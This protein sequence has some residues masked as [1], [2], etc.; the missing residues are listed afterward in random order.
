MQRVQKQLVDAA[1]W[2]PLANKFH[3]AIRDGFYMIIDSP[4]F[5]FRSHSIYATAMRYRR[6][7]RLNKGKVNPDDFKHISIDELR[8]AMVMLDV[9]KGPLGKIDFRVFN[10][11]YYVA[12]A[13]TCYNFW[14]FM[15]K[16][17]ERTENDGMTL[18]QRKRMF[19]S[20]YEEELRPK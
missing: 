11:C 15:K 18:E 2:D 8:E 6:Q 13:Y 1:R 10:W 4:K 14:S 7:A 17:A 5:L 16:D 3:M 19:S 20:D 9:I 12:I